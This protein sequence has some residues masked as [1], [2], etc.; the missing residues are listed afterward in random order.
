[1]LGIALDAS[2]M[3]SYARTLAG[4]QIVR[5]QGLRIDSGDLADE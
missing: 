5:R 1:M 2:A 4:E 3:R